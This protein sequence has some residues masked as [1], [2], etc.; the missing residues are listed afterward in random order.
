MPTSDRLEASAQCKATAALADPWDQSALRPKPGGSQQQG[1]LLSTQILMVASKP[2][3]LLDQPWP[4][5][6]A[7][8][9]YL[10]KFEH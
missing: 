6:Q 9:K 8:S 5:M 4:F 10:W 1:R 7:H 3:S 2:V